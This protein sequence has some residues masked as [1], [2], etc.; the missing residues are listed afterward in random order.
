MLHILKKKKIDYYIDV[1][2]P[3]AE[4]YQLLLQEMG[5]KSLL[6]DMDEL[7]NIKSP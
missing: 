2:F 3:A 7:K 6:I 1:D 5:I 4:K